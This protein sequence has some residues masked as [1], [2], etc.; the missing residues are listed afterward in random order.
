MPGKDPLG[1][2]GTTVLGILG[3]LLAGWLGQSVGWYRP[4]E[5]AGFLSATVGAIAVLFIY[6]LF[7]GRRGRPAKTHRSDID[8]VA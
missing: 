7:A 1:L 6:Y 5:G 4:D 3:A 8:R 2:I